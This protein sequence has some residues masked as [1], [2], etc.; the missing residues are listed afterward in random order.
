MSSKNRHP[1]RELLE[2]VNGALAGESR[3]AV[4][5]HVA[6]CG[7]CAAVAAVVGALKKQA[8]NPAATPD[9]G[10][11]GPAESGPAAYGSLLPSHRGSTGASAQ[12]PS[13]A[14]LRDLEFKDLLQDADIS[15]PAPVTSP[16]GAYPTLESIAAGSSAHLDAAELAS[17]FYGE[18]PK[19]AAAAAAAHVAMCADCASA[20]SLY[21]DSEAAAGAANHSSLAAPGMPEET[22]RAIKEWEENC[23]ANPRP[24]SETPNR[25]MLERFIEIL[26]EHK[27]EIDRVAS[28][29]DLPLGIGTGAH[30]IVPVVVLDSTGGFRG[31]EPFQ[32]ISRPRGL[33]AL[34]SHAQPNR[35]NNLPIHAL[36]GAE[37]KYP[38]VVSGR[39]NR[40]CAEL[41]FGSQRTGSM[42][43]FGYFIVES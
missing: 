21:S 22:W 25:E 16:A 26:R 32:R 11:K 27:D 36:L 43:P 41:D 13:A 10:D 28:G 3:E 15:R 7:K 18:L 5:S 30:Q 33:E 8:H 6:Q 12:G 4:A 42:R 39:I 14:G 37:R 24:E 38:M 2:F 9:S 35:F 29:R 19:E 17:F 20:I 31:V 40:G 1:E 34:Q 23:L